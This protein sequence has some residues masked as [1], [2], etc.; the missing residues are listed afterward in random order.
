MGQGGADPPIPEGN[1][2][3]ARRSCRFATDPYLT[4]TAPCTSAS[5]LL[6][7]SCAGTKSY[8]AI[9]LK[10]YLRITY[11]E[12]QENYDI[13]TLRL[14]AACSASEL[15]SHIWYTQGDSN[16]YLQRWC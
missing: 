9:P 15:L 10:Q 1:G 3:T 4:A 6:I 12:A 7:G 5:S 11:V 2:F 16:P 13:S 8:K 14:T